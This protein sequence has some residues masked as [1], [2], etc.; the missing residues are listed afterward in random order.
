MTGSVRNGTPTRA[1]WMAWLLM[2]VAGSTGLGQEWDW[3][4]EMFDHTSHD[5]G[6]VAR[7]AKVEH[8][9]VFENKY[10]EDVHVESVRSTCSCTTPKI[11]N[12][13]LKTWEKGAI[14]IVVDT[15]SYLGRKD[16]T[17]TVVFDKPF[18]A[19]VR[20][21]VRTYIR[22]DV[23]VQPG[24]VQFGTVIQGNSA[25]ANSRRYGSQRPKTKTRSSSLGGK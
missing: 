4:G 13:S 10:V 2:A 23:V 24:V 20:I 18:P 17:L 22:S 11:I 8:R 9:F 5:F 12:P 21:Q 6:T 14:V 16:A 7:G 15:A 19:E 25:S 3:A 1:G